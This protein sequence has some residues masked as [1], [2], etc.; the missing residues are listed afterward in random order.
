M[1]DPR[2]AQLI[3][4]ITQSLTPGVDPRIIF[5]RSSSPQSHLRLTTLAIIFIALI[6]VLLLLLLALGAVFL[7]LLQKER[8]QST[9]SLSG[10]IPGDSPRSNP[11]LPDFRSLEAQAVQSER[12][13]P[14]GARLDPDSERAQPPSR[15]GRPL[16][17]PADSPEAS[18]PRA[19]LEDSACSPECPSPTSTHHSNGLTLVLP[20]CRDQS[21]D[22]PRSLAQCSD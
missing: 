21:L 19:G 13:G 15:R 17:L 20:A 18:L 6:C 12:P 2:T 4:N 3:R 16:P 14:A 9:H 11:P 22:A 5:I 7:H 1:L 8:K 10:C